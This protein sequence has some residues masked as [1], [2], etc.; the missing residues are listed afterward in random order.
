V[1]ASRR[2]YNQKK[3]VL[4]G[5]CKMLLTRKRRLPM[6]TNADD[7]QKHISDDRLVEISKSTADEFS[8]AERTHL[9]HCDRCNRLLGALFRLQQG[10]Y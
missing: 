3:N 1:I 7:E 4:G 8:E 10:D 9:A 6:S 5:P 2:E